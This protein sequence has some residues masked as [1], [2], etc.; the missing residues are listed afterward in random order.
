[1][2]KMEGDTGAAPYPQ[3]EMCKHPTADCKHKD[4][5]GRCIFEN[6]KYDGMPQTAKLHFF[7][8][9]ICGEVD[10][11]D[12]KEMKAHFCQSC[13]KRMQKA[14]VLPVACKACGKLIESP[15]N[16]IFSGLCQECLN[17]LYDL[18]QPEHHSKLERCYH[19][20]KCPT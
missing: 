20:S 6:C 10:C 2:A 13:I 3:F 5:A 11:I 8:C 18:A 15:T 7:K 12:P 1:M 19:C 4:I 9:I 16:W 14:E 17:N